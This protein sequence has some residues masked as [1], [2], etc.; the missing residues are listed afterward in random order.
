[1]RRWIATGLGLLLMAASVFG[2]NRYA[3]R[4]ERHAATV[5]AI[6]P[7]RLIASGETVD[8]SLLRRVRI[9]EEALPAD[10]LRDEGSIVGR[11]AVAPIGPNETFASWKLADRQ[12]TPRPGE[13]YVSFPT[14]DV[15]NVGNMLRR[16]DRVDVWVE[17]EAPVMLG[18]AAKGALKVAE[19]VRVASVRTPEGA[20][21]AD[22]YGYDAPFQSAAAQRERVRASANGKPGMNTFIMTEPI[23]EAYALASLVGTIKL[24]LPE[25][26]LES[27]GDARL[28][29]EFEAYRNQ[30]IPEEEPT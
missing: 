4:V 16:G 29:D 21:V 9:P 5:E 8:A 13:R 28:T 10:A 23:Y 6:M 7:T 14:T 20:E 12:L 30:L 1:M 17:F 11:A 27:G 19:G 2:F 3:E 26:S 25:P 24:A 18:G 15:T 22:S